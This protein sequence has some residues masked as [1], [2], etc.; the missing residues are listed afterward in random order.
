[1][2]LFRILDV[3][4]TGLA[5]QTVRLN[6]VA[7]NLAN[8]ETVSSSVDRTY[9]ARHPVFAAV[10]EGETDAP[11]ASPGVRVLDVVESATPLQGE[12]R[13]EH[14]LADRDGYV[15]RPNV[16]VV[17]ELANMISASRSYETNVE[18]LNTSKQLV[19]RTLSLGQ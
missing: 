13:P 17:E 5:A 9:R 4:G 1:M 15:Y 11:D 16:N 18:V 2:S 8:A 19:L 6:L 14:P 12:Y 10:L 3:A 7:S